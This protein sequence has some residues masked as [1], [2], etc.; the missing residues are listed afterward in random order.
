[1]ATEITLI[2]QR[3][4]DL[5]EKKDKLDAAIGKL[6]LDIIKAENK[7]SKKQAYHQEKLAV[8]DGA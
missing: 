2:E 7:L 8:V 5:K 1:M 3:L 4:R 6:C